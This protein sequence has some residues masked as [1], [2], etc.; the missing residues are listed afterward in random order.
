[1]N[2]PL[3]FVAARLRVARRTSDAV[4]YAVGRRGLGRIRCCEAVEF[5][6]VTNQMRGIPDHR[7]Y[8]VRGIAAHTRSTEFITDAIATERSGCTRARLLKARKVEDRRGT[9]PGA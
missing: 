1:M 9:R 8:P 2:F 6:Y 5:D 7:S 3:E 4:L